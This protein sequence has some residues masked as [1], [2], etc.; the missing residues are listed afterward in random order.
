MTPH[1]RA[2]QMLAWTQSQEGL[3]RFLH[4]LPEGATLDDALR[5]HRALRQ[6]GRQPS[7]V[8]QEPDP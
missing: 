5:L 1:E 2:A 3:K 4:L 8:M 7:K 6:V